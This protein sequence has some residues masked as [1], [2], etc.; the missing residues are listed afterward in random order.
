MNKNSNKKK[1]PNAVLLRT[2]KFKRMCIDG[3]QL[4]RNF[5][6]EFKKKEDT[7]S[8]LQGSFSMM[9]LYSRMTSFIK[10]SH[11]LT[12]KPNEISMQYA[13]GILQNNLLNSTA[14]FFEKYGKNGEK[15]WNMYP[16][17]LE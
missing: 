6:K 4:W 14:L 15:K 8:D 10:W 3:K 16:N 7:K 5:I 12:G 11:K 2:K 9:N 1:H 13:Y 17:D